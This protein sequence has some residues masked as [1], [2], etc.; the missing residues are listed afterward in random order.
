MRTPVTNFGRA[1]FVTGVNFYLITKIA[2]ETK[3]IFC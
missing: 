3:A 1:E 2:L